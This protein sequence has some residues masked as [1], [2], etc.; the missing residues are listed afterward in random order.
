MRLLYANEVHVLAYLKSSREERVV[1]CQLAQLNMLA[2][3]QT[4]DTLHALT[5]LDLFHMMHVPV[6]LQR[7]G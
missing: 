2:P 7:F 3:Q 4:I 5:L 6:W 1:M